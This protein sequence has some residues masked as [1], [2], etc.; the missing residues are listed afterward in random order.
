MR[1]KYYCSKPTMLLTGLYKLCTFQMEVV[2]R[3]HGHSAFSSF[4]RTEFFSLFSEPFRSVVVSMDYYVNTR[5]VYVCGIPKNC[6][7]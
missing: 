7:N 3:Y 5:L 6:S 2:I 4:L 1:Y